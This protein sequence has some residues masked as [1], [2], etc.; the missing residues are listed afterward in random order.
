MH[1]IFHNLHARFTLRTVGIY[2]KKQKKK[3]TIFRDMRYLVILSLANMEK[4]EKRWYDDVREKI[5]QLRG[6]SN[7]DARDAFYSLSSAN[8]VLVKWKLIETSV[9]DL[10]F[11]Q[12]KI[13]AS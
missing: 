1:D 5:K 10:T 6:F 7:N 11:R 12:H 3:K 2:I 4:I 13:T 8:P 9:L